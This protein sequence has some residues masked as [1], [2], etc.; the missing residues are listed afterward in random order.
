MN[1]LGNTSLEDQDF[2]RAGTLHPEA[3]GQSRGP[4]ILEEFSEVVLRAQGVKSQEYGYRRG[5][6]LIIVFIL[7][8]RFCK[9]S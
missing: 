1:V 4:S 6:T 3:Q 9:W 7:M 8:I 5:A 2:S